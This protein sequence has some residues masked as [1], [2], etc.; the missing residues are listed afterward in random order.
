MTVLKEDKPKLSGTISQAGF[1]RTLLTIINGQPQP[2]R[3]ILYIDIEIL[4]QARLRAYEVARNFIDERME[5]RYDS[6][7][8]AFC[9]GK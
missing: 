6:W 4:N 2:A 1:A 8:G 5:V 9:V 3:P 7:V